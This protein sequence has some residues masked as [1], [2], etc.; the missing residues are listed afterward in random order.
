MV[1]GKNHRIDHRSPDGT[2]KLIE[3]ALLQIAREG[4]TSDEWFGRIYRTR[5]INS[6]LG[7]GCVT[8]WTV[9]DLPDEVIDRIDG[10]I[11]DLPGMQDG[12]K[13]LDEIKQKWRSGLK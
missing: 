2:K 1:D 5:M 12:V 7:V 9:D 3:S 8:P 13:R 4:Q 10:L 11:E 6:Y